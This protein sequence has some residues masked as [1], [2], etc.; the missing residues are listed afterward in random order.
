MTPIGCLLFL[1][2]QDLENAAPLVGSDTEESDD[3]LPD[4]DIH[5]GNKEACV[6]M[7]RVSSIMTLFTTNMTDYYY[8][9]YKTG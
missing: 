9:W 7:V 8:V 6:F 3:D 1:P 5:S 2:K 4:V